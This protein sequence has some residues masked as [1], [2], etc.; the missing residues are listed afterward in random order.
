MEV[1]NQINQYL[2]W[3]ERVA[4]Y[5]QQTVSSKRWI[6]RKAISQLK[7]GNIS[8]LT[9]EIFIAWKRSMIS[10]G[11]G[12]PY[13]VNTSNTRIKQL[14][15]FIKWCYEMD[16]ASPSIKIPMMTPV[17]A[18]D[19]VFEY[20]F[21]TPDQI[22][23]VA[24]Q[25]P[26]LTKTIIKLFSDSGLRISELQNILVS[27]IDFGNCRIF[28]LDKGRKFGYVYFSYRTGLLLRQHIDR[29]GLRQ[30]DYLWQ[31]PRKASSPYSKKAIRSKLKKEFNKCGFVNFRP[32][33]LRHSFATNIIEKGATIDQAR[34]LLRHDS[35]KTT[36]IYIHNLQNKSVEIYRKLMNESVFF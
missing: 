10:G 3:C 36:E 9:S 24:D 16:I 30:S 25:A 13:S 18:S 27:D 35:I 31:S 34:M 1:Y 11:F 6:L 7:I 17:R 26:I 15:V 19:T 2:D 5:T 20:T 33:Q 4:D 12:S 28:V 14:K 32:H 29:F 22:E 23:R 8:E 21:Y